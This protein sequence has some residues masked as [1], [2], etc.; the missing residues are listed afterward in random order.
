MNDKDYIESFIDQYKTYTMINQNNK[1]I[2]IHEMIHIA[3]K[4]FFEKKQRDFDNDLAYG[5]VLH[6]EGIQ[7][8]PKKDN[9]LSLMESY[10]KIAQAL[11]FTVQEK[12]T[13]NVEYYDISWNDMN[14]AERTLIRSIE[15]IVKF[16]AKQLE[17]NVTKHN[18]L[19]EELRHSILTMK[20]NL[21]NNNTSL[22]QK[23]FS[24]FIVTKRNKIAVEHALSESKDVSLIWGA[25]HAPGIIQ[26]LKKSGYA[27][28]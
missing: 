13:Q 17:K 3:P 4:E 5:F 27:L 25:A 9:D 18:E 8:V 2:K 10:R 24:G 20:N 12:P 16:A 14:I 19:A 7:N 21:D 11:K 15:K 28:Q 26:L 6:H 22:L 1:T 23:A